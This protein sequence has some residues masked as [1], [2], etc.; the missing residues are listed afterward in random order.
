MLPDYN[1]E[2]TEIGIKT[3]SSK[4]YFLDVENNRIYSYCDGIEA[5]RQAVYKILNTERYNYLIYDYNYGVELKELFGKPVSYVLAQVKG[6]V[7]QALLADDRIN[8]VT[9][10]EISYNK[11][12]VYVNFRVNSIFGGFNVERSVMANV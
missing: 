3:Q 7:C 11:N 1:F 2:N 6:R 10:F 5:V 8:E 4:T 12:S 9:D